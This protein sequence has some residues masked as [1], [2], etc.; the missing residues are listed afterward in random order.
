MIVGSIAAYLAFMNQPASQPQVTGSMPQP[1]PRDPAVMPPA[2]SPPD[3]DL[4]MGP[5][6]ISN[7]HSV[8]ARDATIM[9][10][11]GGNA[12]IELGSAIPQADAGDRIHIWNWSVS[13]RSRVLDK[14]TWRQESLALSPD[15]GLM[16][17]SAGD[18]VNLKTGAQ[19]KIDL[20]APHGRIGP[21]QFSPDGN[22]LAMF[23]T[24]Y[25]KENPRRITG[26]IVRILS[27]PNGRLLCEFPAG[28]DYA[29][30]IAFTSDGAK[31]AA[32][33]RDRT[34]TLRDADTGRPLR[35]FEPALRT[36]L[37]SLA[38]CPDEKYIAACEADQGTGGDLVIWDL[39]TG[40]ER[41]RLLAADLAKR[42]GGRPYHGTMRFSPDGQHLALRSSGRIFIINVEAGTIAAALPSDFEQHLQW[43]PDGQTL[44]AIAPVA[45]GGDLGRQR[46]DIYPHIQIWNWRTGQRIQRIGAARD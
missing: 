23:I 34:V 45:G 12:P 25:E 31:I 35:Q 18:I 3:H 14:V 13:S 30:R 15:G 37:M 40:Q 27:F 1:T 29:L 36:Q 22:R 4:E 26:H 21:M 39:T 32:G 5:A 44:T 43:S 16:V 24:Q 10:A 11:N 7:V 20:S 38:I 6:W 19:S 17:W 42:G 8:T 46:V 33:N 2:P 9:I 41:H 28:E